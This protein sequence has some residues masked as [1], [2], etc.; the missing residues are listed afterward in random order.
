MERDKANRKARSFPKL[1]VVADSLPCHDWISTCSTWCGEPRFGNPV[2]HHLPPF[3]LSCASQSKHLVR[4]GVRLFPSHSG[5]LGICSMSSPFLRLLAPRKFVILVLY[6]ICASV[7]IVYLILTMIPSR[8]VA[9][10]YHVWNPCGP[11]RLTMPS[12][13]AGNGPG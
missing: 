2:A 4:S 9:L 8:I 13:A 11:S 7:T 12:V 1:V 5:H 6:N 3:A 10:A